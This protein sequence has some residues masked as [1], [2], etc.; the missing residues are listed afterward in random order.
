MRILVLGAG[1]TGG[2][3]GGRLAAAGRDV[4]FLVRPARAERLQQTGLRIKSPLGDAH[5]SKPNCVLSNEI[6]HP[7]DLIILSCK[8]YDLDE[9]MASIAP[10]VGDNTVILPLLNGMRHLDVLDAKF[11]ASNVLGGLCV[12]AATTDRDGTIVHLNDVSSLTFGERD[13]SA[14]PRVSTISQA[15]AGV[16]FDARASETIIHDMW[17]K[18][19]FLATLASSTCL[20]RASIGDIIAAPAGLQS[21]ESMFAE[22][23]E[24]ATGQGFPPR[25]KAIIQANAML[26]KQSSTF[27]SSMMRD[28]ENRARIEADHILGDLLARATSAHSHSLIRLAYTHLKAYEARRAREKQ[29]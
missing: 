25:E 20:M 27:T 2:Y 29:A 12:I 3:F 26:T 10:V 16:T 6:T 14:S 22:C 7:Y 18:W 28:I 5:I 4:T 9:A 24:I 19:V 11:G 8:A 15:M 23:S 13:G 1:A 17:E 21:I